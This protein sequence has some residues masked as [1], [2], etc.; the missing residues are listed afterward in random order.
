MKIITLTFVLGIMLVSIAVANEQE[1]KGHHHMNMTEE[2]SMEDMKEEDQIDGMI[3]PIMGG[4]VSKKV[5]TE[6]KGKKYYFCCPGCIEEF[7]S[8]PEFYKRKL[9]MLKK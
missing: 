2:M 6:Y 5:F 8:K 1:K 9:K 4:P 7:N 3:C